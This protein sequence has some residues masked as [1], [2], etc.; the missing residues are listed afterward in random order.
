MESTSCWPVTFIR[1]NV[2]AIHPGHGVNEPNS[3]Q[4]DTQQQQQQQPTGHHCR[5]SS[6]TA[7]HSALV[8]TQWQQ[9]PTAHC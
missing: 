6:S 7:Q 2:S 3:P 1:V 8:L 5:I 4:Q 9:Q